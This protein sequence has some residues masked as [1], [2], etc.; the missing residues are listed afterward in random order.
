MMDARS[1]F[2]LGC[3][4]VIALIRGVGRSSKFLCLIFVRSGRTFITSITSMHAYIH[5]GMVEGIMAELRKEAA[6][7]EEDKWM[8][9]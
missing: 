7:L 2:G 1:G 5:T 4:L 8:Y 3:A 6:R 9:E